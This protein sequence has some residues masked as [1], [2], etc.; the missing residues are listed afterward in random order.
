MLSDPKNYYYN[1]NVNKLFDKFNSEQANQ[2]LTQVDETSASEKSSKDISEELKAHIT[3]KKQFLEPPIKI[4]RV[5]FS[6]K[7]ILEA[8][9]SI[10]KIKNILDNRLP[11]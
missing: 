7:S 8:N 2:L 3:R 4:L 11:H 5:P 1:E 10:T 9:Y 6:G